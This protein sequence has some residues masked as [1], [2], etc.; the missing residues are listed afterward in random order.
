MWLCWVGLQALRGRG[1]AA[2]YE[3]FGVYSAIGLVGGGLVWFGLVEWLRG[4]GLRAY[5]S[6]LTFFHF[7]V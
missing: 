3:S 4:V 1:L 2:R 6:H 5:K 7:G